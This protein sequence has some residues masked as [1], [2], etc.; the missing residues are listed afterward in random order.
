MFQA[1]ASL[2]RPL[3]SPLACRHD[4]P[5]SA[6]KTNNDMF[7]TAAAS[8]RPDN[9]LAPLANSRQAAIHQKRRGD[10]KHND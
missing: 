2:A 9:L 7:R 5:A 8:D 4:A 1:G 10:L 3:A 6:M